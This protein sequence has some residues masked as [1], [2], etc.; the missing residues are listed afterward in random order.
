MTSTH[1]RI[2]AL[3]ARRSKLFV[4]INL[5]GYNASHPP[6]DIHEHVLN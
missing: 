5:N 2:L 6:Y 4:T 1:S 3:L